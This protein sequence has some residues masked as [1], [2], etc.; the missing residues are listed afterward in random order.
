MLM[1][2]WETTPA[3]TAVDLHIVAPTQDVLQPSAPAPLPRQHAV[4]HPSPSPLLDSL[5]PGPF[6]TPTPV[7][8]KGFAYNEPPGPSP[9]PVSSLTLFDSADMLSL[10]LEDLFAA[11]IAAFNVAVNDACGQVASGAPRRQDRP[12]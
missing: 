11:G 12:T 3:A 7:P 5:S 10:S 8:H 1:Y 4:R 9:S 6:T 2:V